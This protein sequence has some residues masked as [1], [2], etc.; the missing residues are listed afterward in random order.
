M[1]YDFYIDLGHLLVKYN[2]LTSLTHKILPFFLY[3][4]DWLY[5]GNFGKQRLISGLYIERCFFELV[6]GCNGKGLGAFLTCKRK[7]R[8]LMMC[9]TCKMI[10]TL[11]FFHL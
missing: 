9:N 2:V 6:I 7:V 5:L 8:S 10:V 11:N 1:L 3:L 4:F